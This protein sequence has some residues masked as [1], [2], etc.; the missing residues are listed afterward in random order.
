MH[1]VTRLSPQ[2]KQNPALASYLSTDLQA[3]NPYTN[4][5]K[6]N[7]GYL[8]VSE[9][10]HLY[11]AEYGNPNGIPAIVLHGG[12]C[13]GCSPDQASWFNPD[14]YRVIL[15]DQ[16]GAHLSKPAGEMQENTT[17]NAL[18]DLETLREHLNIERWVVVGGSWGSALG[19]LYAE[20]YPDK[21]V[22]LIL[23]SIFLARPQDTQAIFN[24]I[25][26]LYPEIWQDFGA[27]TNSQGITEIIH[28]YNQQLQNEVHETVID[29][30]RKFV[31]YNCYCGTLDPDIGKIEKLVKNDKFVLALARGFFSY[32]AN[33]FYLKPNQILDNIAPMQHLPVILLH[34]RYDTIC[35]TKQAYELHQALPNSVLSIL[36]LAGHSAQD[37]PLAR[38]LVAATDAMQGIFS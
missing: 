7:Q 23:R 26:A 31:Y 38:A 8:T 25:K 19:M 6:F 16:R 22:G 17:N 3:K 5:E 36:Q 1:V 10:H 4:I 32:S 9:L 24:G 2:A 33:N 21:C 30:A 15:L 20:K 27:L 29:L 18:Q 14:V 35:F 34:G 37:L 28:A 11:Y 13:A 12:P